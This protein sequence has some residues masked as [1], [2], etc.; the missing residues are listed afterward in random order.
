MKNIPIV[1]LLCW[2]A[3]ALADPGPLVI[4]KSGK[5]RTSAGNI[6][7]VHLE[8]ATG[9]TELRKIRL[10]IVNGMLQTKGRVW[11]YEG[12]GDGYILARFDYRGHTIVT[13][14]EYNQAL[15]QL[16]FHG[17]SEAY[18]CE[19]LQVNGVCYKNHKGYFKYTENLRTSI[20]RNLQ[21]VSTGV[22]S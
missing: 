19:N 11:T 1:V 20:A 8:I 21:L 18:E 22:S 16:K 2:A 7:G 6:E 15:V 9:T 3:S 13:R 5:G 14:I 17:G 4:D 12:E 10:A